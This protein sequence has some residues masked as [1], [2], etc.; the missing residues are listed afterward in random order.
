MFLSIIIPVY[1]VECYLGECISSVL[2]QDIPF[3]DYE[4]IIINDG[5]TD[6][7]LEV[8][9][10][11]TKNTINTIVIN[12]QNQGLSHARNTGLEIAKGQYIWFIDSDD[13]IKSNS[14]KNIFTTISTN[15][16]PDLIEISRLK[17]I[18]DSEKKEIFITH[19]L[20]P[21]S[22]K[23]YLEK[24]TYQ[25]SAAVYIIKK[26][27]LKTNNLLFVE[28]IFHEDN[29]FTPRVLFFAKHIAFHPPIVYI[30]RYRKGSITQ[31]KSNKRISDLFFV[32]EKQVEFQKRYGLTKNDKLI[33]NKIITNTILYLISL[34]SEFGDNEKAI[35]YLRKIRSHPQLIN[36]FLMSKNIK[37]KCG[38]LLLKISPKLFWK[39]YIYTS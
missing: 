1:N 21:M 37:H 25:I 19:E 27:F 3:S 31:T 11:Y 23:E 28:N 32:A 35:V 4:I 15:N 36:Q 30:H 29:E 38:Y 33:I 2:N 22:G 20:S 6:N 9:K 8:I 13:W 17:F 24:N 12:Q 5:S 18:N 10:R 26:E 34:L 14:L 39:L 16:Y 7:S